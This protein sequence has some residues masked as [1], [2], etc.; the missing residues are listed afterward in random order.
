MTI[1]TSA[2]LR[3]LAQHMHDLELGAYGSAE[4]LRAHPTRPAIILGHLPESPVLA[5]AINLYGRDP[6]IDTVTTNPLMRV[7]LAWRSDTEK[8][9]DAVDLADQASELLHS[10]T[11]GVWPG[12]VRPL[13]MYR[14]ISAPADRDDNDRWIKADSYE[15][16]LNPGE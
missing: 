8:M 10:D 12:G 5:V 3:S 16:R 13:W 4:V 7:Q 15:I 2:V 6:D 1:R 14:T 9:L 11:P